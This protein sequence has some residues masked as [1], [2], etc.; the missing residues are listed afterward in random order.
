MAIKPKPLSKVNFAVVTAY[1]KGYRV[2]GGVPYGP[3]GKALKAARQE[4]NGYVRLMFSVKVNKEP[5]KVYAH[6][7]VAY[8]KY[9]SRIFELGIYVRHLDGNSLNNQ[10]DN[11]VIGS[12]SQNEMDKQP[13]IRKNVAIK[14]ASHN[15]RFTDEQMHHIKELHT[16]GWGY[17]KLMGRFG[18][19]SKGTL[20]HIL[21][22][23][24]VTNKVA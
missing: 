5:R 12:Q 4:R 7:L 23:N 13:E 3:S 19:S 1:Q 24:Y 9:G 2:V 21:N 10:D 16:D 6:K 20:H 11:I 8:Q 22:N 18:I 15:R 14:A 17:K